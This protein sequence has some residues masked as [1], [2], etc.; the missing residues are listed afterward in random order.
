MPVRREGSTDQRVAILETVQD[1]LLD[2]AEKTDQRMDR[3]ER[4][5]WQAVG[6]LGI[7]MIVAQALIPIILDKIGVVPL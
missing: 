3:V 6:A 1:R 2:L 5:I 4:V 7:L